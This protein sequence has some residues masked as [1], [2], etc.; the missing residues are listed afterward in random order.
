[1]PDDSNT[2][3][4]ELNPRDRRL[5]DR[6]RSRVVTP[7]PGIRSGMGDMLLLLPDLT[8]LLARLVRDS[9]VPLPSKVIAM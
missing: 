8:V 9:R 3:T 6:L 2:V 5:Y 1:M 4:I 7:N